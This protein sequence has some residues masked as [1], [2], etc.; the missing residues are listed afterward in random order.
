MITTRSQMISDQKVMGPWKALHLRTKSS[1]GMNSVEL[2]QTSEDD[3]LGKAK[4]TCQQFGKLQATD[5]KR[6]HY[7]TKKGQCQECQTGH[8]DKISPHTL[9]K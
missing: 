7:W 5:W 8:D 4:L 1:G 9:V 6:Y 2:F 3:M